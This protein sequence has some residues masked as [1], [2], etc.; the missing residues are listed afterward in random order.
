MSNDTNSPISKISHY[1]K[2]EGHSL[3]RIQLN[4]DIINAHVRIGYS[5]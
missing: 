1:V 3:K 4:T 5:Y 2:L